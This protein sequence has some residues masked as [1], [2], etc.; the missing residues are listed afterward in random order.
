MPNG[1]TFIEDIEFDPLDGPNVHV[2]FIS[3]EQRI[4]FAVAR[5][6]VRRA[7]G[8][9]ARMLDAADRHQAVVVE[10]ARHN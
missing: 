7:A 3:G 10:F 9:A 2:T 6:T 4:R 5:S 1:C 8:K